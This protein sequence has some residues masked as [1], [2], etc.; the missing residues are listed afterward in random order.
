MTPDLIAQLA[1]VAGSRDDDRNA[2]VGADPADEEAKP[3]QLRQARLGG[4]GPD[5]LGQ[6]CAALR[7]LDG[8]VVQLVG[9]RL[10]PDSQPLPVGDLAQP[11]SVVLVAADEA[12]VVLAKAED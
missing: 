1:G 11:D 6:R 12:E 2:V 4:R 3:L 10:D 9:G 7:A 5:E 8:E